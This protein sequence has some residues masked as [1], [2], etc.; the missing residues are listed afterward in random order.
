VASFLE[1][2]KWDASTCTLLEP[3]KKEREKVLLMK[4]E[5]KS[6]SMQYS[7]HPAIVDTFENLEF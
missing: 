6:Q 2:L 5:L 4:K 1:I 7:L 3:N